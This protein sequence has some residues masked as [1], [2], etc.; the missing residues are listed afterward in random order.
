MP[1]RIENHE[2]R[3]SRLETNYG[4]VIDKINSMEK[5]QL[6]IQNVVLKSSGDQKDL[7][8]NLI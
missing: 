7:L 8:N 6:E 3:I 1:Q 4:E 5:G 2:Q